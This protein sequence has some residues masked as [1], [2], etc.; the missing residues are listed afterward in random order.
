MLSYRGLRLAQ[1][2]GS[3]KFV[4]MMRKVSAKV[5]KQRKRKAVSLLCWN[6]GVEDCAL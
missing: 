1:R 5:Y 2:L 4:D 3:A 6:S